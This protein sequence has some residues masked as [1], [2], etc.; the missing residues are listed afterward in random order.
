M[1]KKGIRSFKVKRSGQGTG[2]NESSSSSGK[3]PGRP[4]ADHNFTPF[5]TLIDPAKR[6]AL[7]VVSIREKI[8]IYEIIDEALQAWL[9]SRKV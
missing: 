7:A 1:E 8:K 6:E 2:K 9:T 5:T 4:P 3:S